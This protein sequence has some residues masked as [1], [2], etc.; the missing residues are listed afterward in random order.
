MELAAFGS[1][2]RNLQRVPSNLWFA[3]GT[4]SGVHA[5]YM[6]VARVVLSG[7]SGSWKCFGAVVF[8][9]DLAGSGSPTMSLFTDKIMGILQQTWISRIDSCIAFRTGRCR[10]K[11]P[12][13]NKSVPRY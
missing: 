8:G 5:L 13:P 2:V 4:S 7:D 12:T 11:V 10:I 6:V 9:L 1:G 3:L